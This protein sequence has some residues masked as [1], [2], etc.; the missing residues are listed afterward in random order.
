[1]T[2]K[3]GL[4]I[5]SRIDVNEISLQELNS[6]ITS[7]L[8]LFIAVLERAS[9]RSLIDISLLWTIA[10][11]LVTILGRL[12]AIAVDFVGD[13]WTQISSLFKSVI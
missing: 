3:D 13:L 6:L 11:S 8:N 2:V 7:I 12:R 10:H 1:M 9:S 5:L 4:R